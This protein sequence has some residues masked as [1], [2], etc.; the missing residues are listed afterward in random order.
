MSPDPDFQEK[1]RERKVRR[2]VFHLIF[3][4]LALISGGFLIWKL[5]S[6]VLPIIVGA[7]LA[8]LF[9]PVKERF[10][11]PWLP[12]ELQVL[13]S[14]AAIGLV[15][16]FAFDTARKHIPD[17]QQK[18]EL[19]VRLKYK[20][21]EKYQQLV[22]KSPEGKSSMLVGLIE[23]EV[24]PLM[25]K[26]NQ[27][28][29]LD[30]QERELFLKYRAGYNGNSPIENKFFEYFQANQN[31]RK[32][33]TPEEAPAAAP[34]ATAA[35][36]AP[37]EPPAA[38]EGSNLEAWILAP[39][40][41]VFLGFDNGQMRRYFI[42]LV[43]NRY[44]ELSLTLLDRLDDAI[45]KYLRGTLTECFLVGL[46]LCLGLILLG[47]PIG[48]AVA[49]SLISGLANT[50]PW[51]GTVIAL[52]ISLSYALIAENIAPLIP[53][54]NP[55]N[56]PLYVLILVGI[57]RVLDDVVFQPF[58]LGSAVNIHPLVVVVAIIGGSLIMGLWGMVFAIPTVVVVKTAVET[59]FKE[60]KDYRII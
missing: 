10:K 42:S 23:K 41:F 31:T 19:K 39:L 13:C 30:P 52:V 51:L 16:F 40:I 18:L 6:L 44:F 17:D 53:G 5:S 34:A 37:V 14:F 36:A 33:V 24:D 56:L 47:I 43:P 4:I 54:L 20:L 1:E 59:L 15:L 11:I 49:I 3:A 46:T 60:L 12:H 27:L 32:Y 21:N 25:D 29:E 57:T 8:F 45:G 58:V 28:L 48:A 55:N 22:P 35:V 7:L 26:V 38:R 50:I 2:R 9:R